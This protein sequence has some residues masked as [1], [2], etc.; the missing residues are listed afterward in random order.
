MKRQKSLRSRSR[1]YRKTPNPYDL[2]QVDMTLT[3]EQSLIV[4]G[5]PP[6]MAKAMVKGAFKGPYG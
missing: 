5:V 2:S 6:G 4:R 1:P 3:K